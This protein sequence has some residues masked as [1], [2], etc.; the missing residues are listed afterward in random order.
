MG[1]IRYAGASDVSSDKQSAAGG[2]TLTNQACPP[3]VTVGAPTGDRLIAAGLIFL[4]SPVFLVLAAG[5]ALFVGRPIFYRGER[6]GK[7]RAV[8]MVYKFRTLPNGIQKRLGTS[9]FSEREEILPALARFL[10]ETRLDELP[11]LVNVVRGE[12]R[13]F[14]PRPERREV[15]ERYGR[16]DPDYELRFETAPGLF[17]ISQLLTP[18][19]APKRLRARLDR[20]YLKAGGHMTLPFFV[21]AALAMIGKS[22][23]AAGR[24]SWQNAVGLRMVRG[25]REKRS[26]VRITPSQATIQLFD[27]GMTPPLVSGRIL[28]MNR[29]YIRARFEAPLPWSFIT[30]HG[31]RVSIVRRRKGSPRIKNAR[32]HA[33]VERLLND[34]HSGQ[35]E[36][37]LAYSADSTLNRYMVDQYFLKQAI[38]T[39]R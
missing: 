7:R 32:C 3:E 33:H 5:V 17:G 35:P 11:Q 31:G 23:A 19:S 24:Y 9:L 34:E 21:Y 10:R 36:Y 1:F 4:L 6:L 26:Q 28:D 30:T 25:E 14:G 37:L 12:M 39:R 16:G 2:R 15:Y 18:H 38:V 8:Y 27:P 22:I 20:R 13:L 29:D